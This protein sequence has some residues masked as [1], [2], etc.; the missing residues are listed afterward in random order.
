MIPQMAVEANVST[1]LKLPSTY[2]QQNSQSNYQKILSRKNEEK[3]DEPTCVPTK[4]RAE[5][6]NR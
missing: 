6:N 4:L 5:S 2:K 1:V 3:D